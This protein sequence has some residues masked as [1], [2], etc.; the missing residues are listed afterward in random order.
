MSLT[1]VAD[2]QQTPQT[3]STW[4][5]SGLETLVKTG[6]ANEANLAQTLSRPLPS[7]LRPAGNGINISASA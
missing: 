6:Q 4:L 1:A 5:V 2:I 3:D 7:D